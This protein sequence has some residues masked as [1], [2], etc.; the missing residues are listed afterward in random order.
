MHDE[1]QDIETL[2]KRYEQLNTKKTQAE[3]LLSTANQE[4][5]RLKAEAKSK[6][7]TDDLQELEMKLKEMEEENLRK[8]RDYQKLLDQIE[9]ELLSVEGAQPE[10]ASL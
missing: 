4:L 8:R 1:P 6:Y 7:G 5:E 9:R 3:T 10:E 2:R